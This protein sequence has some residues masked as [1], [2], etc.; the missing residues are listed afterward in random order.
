MHSYVLSYIEQEKYRL[1]IP[2]E[3]ERYEVV[4]N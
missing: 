1:R 4:T 3:G 2:N